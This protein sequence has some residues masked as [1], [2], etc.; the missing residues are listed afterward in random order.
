[1]YIITNNLNDKKKKKKL[2]VVTYSVELY[3]IGFI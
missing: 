2:S 1:M 3:K